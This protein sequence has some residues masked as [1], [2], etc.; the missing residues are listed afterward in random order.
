MSTVSKSA[1]HSNVRRTL[2]VIALLLFILSYYGEMTD[3][4]ALA[5]LWDPAIA[6]MCLLIGA[7]IWSTSE[8]RRPAA[9]VATAGFVTFA[10]TTL[11]EFFELSISAVRGFDTL[12]LLSLLVGF[13]AYVK[14]LWDDKSDLLKLK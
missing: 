9:V 3:T 6:L 12:V 4:A 14:I 1:L 10:V 5:G 13:G 2:A 7:G 11:V 8:Y